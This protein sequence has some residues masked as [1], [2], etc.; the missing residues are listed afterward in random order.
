MKQTLKLILLFLGFYPQFLRSLI[1]DPK[2]SSCDFSANCSQCQI[3]YNID[4]VSQNCVS[5]CNNRMYFFEPSKQCVTSCPQGFIENQQTKACSSINQCDQLNYQSGTKGFQF[6]ASSQVYKNLLIVSGTQNQTADR[7]SYFNVYTLKNDQYGF[8]MFGTLDGHNSSVISQIMLDEQYS[9]VL[10]TVSKNMI[11]AWDMQYGALKSRL[12]F[13]SKLFVDEN[14]FYLDSNILVLNY[15]NKNQFAVFSHKDWVKSLFSPTQI[16]STSSFFTKFQK[17]H[18]IPI[19]GYELLSTNYLISFDSN[20]VIQWNINNNQEQKIYSNFNFTL[21]QIFSFPQ[22]QNQ[23]NTSLIVVTYQQNNMISFILSDNNP[24]ILSFNT[25]HQSPIASILFDQNIQVQNLMQQNIF[26]F[27]SYSLT[28][29][30]IFQFNM[31]TYQYLLIQNFQSQNFLIKQMNNQ[32][33]IL[34]SSGLNLISTQ[35]QQQQPQQQP[36]LETLNISLLNIFQ[37]KFSPVDK[38]IDI[39]Q[40]NI[41]NNQAFLVIGRELKIFSPQIQQGK[42]VYILKNLYSKNIDYY[43]RHNG[44]INGVAFD[45]S[46]NLF[47]TYSSDGSFAVWDTILNNMLNQKPLYFQLPP[48][49]QNQ[50]FCQI[51][52]KKAQVIMNGV[53]LTL[54]SNNIFITWNFSRYSVSLRQTYQLPS[55]KLKILNY[56]FFN[57]YL[58]MSNNKEL[59]IYNFSQNETQLINTQYQVFTENITQIQLAQLNT[60]FYLL[61]TL[62]VLSPNIQSF[63]RVKYLS[64]LTLFKNT[65]IQ[66]QCLELQYFQQTQKIIVNYYSLNLTVISFPSLNSTN[67]QSADNQIAVQVYS[68]SQNQFLIITSSTLMY[69]YLPNGTN[70]QLNYPI[71]T[72]LPRTNFGI[73]N[74]EQFIVTSIGYS[75]FQNTGFSQIG[76]Y[77]INLI[78]SNYRTCSV[79]PFK[80]EVSSLSIINDSIVFVGF[81]NGNIQIAEYSCANQICGSN[82]SSIYNSITNQYLKKSYFFTPSKLIIA[83]LYNKS[84]ITL[85][86]GHSQSTTIQIIQDDLSG[87]MITY[88]QE[89]TQN[90][91]KFDQRNLIATQ[92]QNGHNASVDYAFLDVNRSVLIT[93]SADLNDLQVIV[94]SY[95][96]SI[97]LNVFLDIQQFNQVTPI[98]SIATALIDMVS[99]Q[100][101]ILTTQ[102]TLFSFNYI[103]YK[104]NVQYLVQNVITIYLDP[105]FFKFYLLCNSNRIQIRNYFT[106]NLENEIIAN[107]P[108]LLQTIAPQVNWIVVVSQTYLT[109]INRNKQS[110]QSSIFC[111]NYCGNYVVS[112][113]LNILFS[114]ASN[115]SNGLDVYNIING[116]YLYS[117]NGYEDLNI[118]TIRLVLIDDVNYLLF[119]GKLSFFTTAV[120]N[121]LTQQYIGYAFESIFLFYGS[122]NNQFN[123]LNVASTGKFYIRSLQEQVVS[124]FK[125]QDYY[126]VKQIDYYTSSQGDIYYLDGNQYVRKYSQLDSQIKIVGQLSNYRQ[127]QYFNGF[128]YVLTLKQLIKYTDSFEQIPQNSAL[129]IFGNQI[130]GVK[131]NQIFISTFNQTIVQVDYQQFII[132]NQINLPS[133]LIQYQFIESFNDLLIISMDGSFMRYNYIS[134][135][136][137]IQISAGYYYFF[138]NLDFNLIFLASSVRQQIEVYSYSNQIANFSNFLLNNITYPNTTIVR[139]IFMDQQFS[140][141]YISSQNDRIIDIYSYQ[142][143]KQALSISFTKVNYIPYINAAKYLKLRFVDKYIQVQIPWSISYYDRQS[144]N[145]YWQVQDPMFIQSINQYMIDPSF[146]ELVFI[147]QNT[148]LTIV[149]QNIATQTFNL[150]V[151]YSLDYPIIYKLQINK[152]FD[153]YVFQILLLVSGDILNYQ[154]SIPIVNGIPQQSYFNNCNLQISNPSAQFQVSNQLLNLQSYFSSFNYQSQGIQILV[155]FKLKFFYQLT[156]FIQYYQINGSNFIYYSD[157]MKSLNAITQYQG[158]QFSDSLDVDD[159]LFINN[160]NFEFDLS[161]YNLVL[162]SRPVIAQFSSFTNVLQFTNISFSQPDQ[163]QNVNTTIIIENMSSVVFKNITLRQI[164]LQGN[165]SLFSFYNCSNVTLDNIQIENIDLF[166]LVSIFKFQA[167]SNLSIRNLQLKQL[168]YQDSINRIL[169]ETN[170]QK[171]YLF[172][173]YQIQNFLMEKAQI[174][175]IKGDGNQII[176]DIQQSKQNRFNNI[177]LRSILNVQTISYINFFQES[178]QTRFLDNDIFIL[179]NF[180]ISNYQNLISSVIYF[181]GTQLQILNSQFSYI[182]CQNCVGSSLNIYQTESIIISNSQFDNNFGLNGGSLGLIE[183]VGNQSQIINSQFINNKA[184]NSGGA[185]YLSKSY[186]KLSNDLF[187]ENSALIGGAIRYINGKPKYFTKD[188]FKSSGVQFISNS[189]EIHSQNWGSYLQYVTPQQVNIKKNRLIQQQLQE[190][191]NLSLKQRRLSKSQYQLKDIQ[192]GGFVDLQFQIFDEEN[193]I[194]NYNITKC[195]YQIY[196]QQICDELSQ[197]ELSIFSEDVNIV[198]IVGSYMAQYNSFQQSLSAFQI[199]GIQ[200]VGNPSSTQFIILSAFGLHQYEEIG[201]QDLIYERKILLFLTQI[202]INNFLNQKVSPNIYQERYEINFR[203]CIIGE[204]YQLSSDIYYC[205]ECLQGTYSLET[206]NKSKNIMQCKLCPEEASFCFKNQMELKSGY[207]KSN[208][209]TDL[210]YKCDFDENCKGDQTTNYCNEGHLG[211]LCQFCDEYGVLWGQQYQ[212]N[213]KNGCVNCTTM[214]ILYAI[215]NAFIISTILALFFIYNIFQSIKASQRVVLAHYLRIFKFLCISRSSQKN[216]VNLAVKA[217]TSFLQLY[218]LISNFN[219]NLPSIVSI[220]PDLFGQPSSSAVFNTACQIAYLVTD[221][222][223]HLYWKSLFSILS[224]LMFAKLMGLYYFI[225]VHKKYNIQL[226]K[227]QFIF[228]I[229]FLFQYTQP[230]IVQYLIQLITCRQFDGKSYIRADYTYE[231]YTEQHK[232]YILLLIGPGLLL[233]RKQLNDALVRL[234]YGYIYQDY[235]EKCFYWEIAKSEQDIQKAIKNWMM[236]YQR[237]QFNKTPTLPISPKSPSIYMQNQ[238]EFPERQQLNNSNQNMMQRSGYRIRNTLSSLIAKRQFNINQIQNQLQVDTIIETQNYRQTD[239]NSLSDSP[240]QYIR[241]S[242]LSSP[243][244][245]KRNQGSQQSNRTIQIDTQMENDLNS[246]S[247]APNTLQQNTICLSSFQQCWNLVCLSLNLYKKCR[248]YQGGFYPKFLESLLCDSKCASCDFLANCSQCQIGYNLDPNSQNCISQCREGMF[249]YEPTQQCLVNCPQGFFENQQTKACASINQCDQIT[250]QSD[251]KGFNY[252]INSQVYQDLLIVRGKQ[253]QTVVEN[254]L[255]IYKLKN[256]QYGFYTYGVLEGHDSSIIC[257]TLL[258]DQYSQVLISASKKMIKAWDMEYGILKSSLNLTDILFVDEFSFYLDKTIL[259]LNYFDRNQ[260]A[261]FRHKDWVKSLYYPDQIA[262]TSSLFTMFKRIHTRPIIGYQTL[263]SNY[264]ISF[265]NSIVIRWNILDNNEYYIYSNFNYTLNQ[266]Y[267]FPYQNNQSSTITAITYVENTFISFI[268]YNN[269]SQQIENKTFILNSKGLSLIQQPSEDQN[270]QL[271]NIFQVSFSSSDK[272]M[273]IQK[274][275]VDNSLAFIIIGREL[276]IF[277][278]QIQQESI[279]FT[280]QSLIS[281][282]QGSYQRHNGQVNGVVYDQSQNLFITYSS[283]GS[284]AVWDTIQNSI[285]NQKPLYFQFPPWCQFQDFCQTPLS[286]AQLIMNRVILSLYKIVTQVYSPIQNSFLIITSLSYMYQYLPNGTSYSLNYPVNYP[287]PRTNFGQVYRQQFVVTSTGFSYFQNTGFS[288]IGNYVINLIYEDYRTCSVFPFQD[289]ISSLSVINDSFIFVGFKNGN[290]KIA[291]YS[292]TNQVLGTNACNTQNIITNPY[293]KKTYYFALSTVIVAD[294]YSKTSTSIPYGHPSTYSVKVIQDDLNGNMITYSQENSQNLYKFDQKSQIATQFQNGHNSSVDYA[295]LDLKNNLVI[296]HSADTKDLQV[297]VWS[298]IYVSKLYV[299]LDIKQFNLIT[300]IIS[301]AAALLDIDRQNKQSYQSNIYCGD[302]CGNYVVSDKLNLLFSYASNNSNGLDV[303]NI[304]NGQY[305]YSIIGYEDLN[306]GTI[307]LV[308]IDDVN[309][310]LFIGKLSFFT[311]AVFNYLTQ[312]YV[313]YAFDRNFLFYG[314]INNQ[315][316]ALNGASSTRYYMRTLQEYVVSTFKFQDQYKLKK[317]DYYTSSIGELYFIDANGYV[318]RYNQQDEQIKIV[319]QITSYRQIQYFNGFLLVLTLQ[320]LFKYTEGFQQVNQGSFINMFGDQILGVQNNQIFISTFNQTIVQVD[321]QQFIIVNQINLQSSIIQYQFIESYNDL[322]LTTQDGRLI[323]Y[324]YINNSTLT[325]LSGGYYLFYCNLDLNLIFIVSSLNQQIE[326]YSYSNQLFN[327]TNYLLRNITYPNTTIIRQMFIDQQFNNLY[328]AYKNDRIIDIYSFQIN[329]LSPNINF[330]KVNFIP[331]INVVQSLKL[332]LVDQYI[333]VRIPSSITFYDRQSFN[334]YWQ[335][336]DPLFIQSINQYMIDPSF[337]ELVFITQNTLLVIVYQKISSKTFNLLVKQTLDYPIIYN[338]K[339]NKSFD[340]YFIQFLLLVSGDIIKY[341]VSIPIVNNIPQQ[342]YFNNCFLQIDNP[343]TQFQI[344]NQLIDLQ[345]YFSTFN[346]QSEAIQL[347]INGSNSLYYYDGMNS[348]NAQ[349]KYQG[350]Q[351]NSNL[352]IEDNL[353]YQ[354]QN[355]Q[356]NIINYNL[357]LL[358]KPVIAQFN[359]QTNSLQ[360]TNITFIQIDQTQQVNSTIIIQNMTN[361]IFQNV[362][363]SQIKLQG[364]ISLFN[365]FNCSNIIFENIQIENIQ[366]FD[367]VSIFR[368]QAVSNITLNNLSINLYTKTLDDDS[369]ELSK[370]T[371][372]NYENQNQSLISFQGTY[373]LIQNSQFSF[374]NCQDC[375]GSSINIYKSNTVIISNSIF[376]NNTGLNGGS[377]GIIE[378]QGNQSSIVNSQ[379]IKNYAFNSGG[380]IYLDSSYIK[381]TQDIFKEN[382]ALIGGAIRYLNG[383][384]INFNSKEFQSNGVQFISNSASI[385]S[386]N[387]GSYLQYVVLKQII[388]SKDRIIEQQITNNHDKT[389]E[390]SDKKNQKD[391]YVIDN[392]QSG[393]FINLQLQIYDEEDN[394]LNYNI[395]NCINQIYPQEICDELSQIEIILF[396]QDTNIVRVVGSYVAQYN[397]FLQPISA[398]QILGIQIMGDPKSQQFIFLQAQGLKQY[399]KTNQFDL[400]Q[401]TSTINYQ[402]QYKLVFRDC[403]IGEIYKLSD[404]I[405]QCQEC[406]KGTYSLQTPNKKYFTDEQIQCKSCPEEAS[407]CFKNQMELKAGYWKS[408]NSTDLIYQCEIEQ[409]CNGDQTKQYCIEGH[410]GPL[411]QFCDE[412]GYLWGQ[413][414]QYDSKHGCINCTTLNIISALS[415]FIII[416]IVIIFFF[417]FNIFQTIKASQKVI[418]A[419]YLRFLKLLCIS[420]SSQNNEVNLVVKALTSF[421]Q[422]YKLISNFDLKLPQILSIA[423]SLFGEPSSQAILNSACQIASLASEKMPHLYWKLLFS[424]LSP[425]IFAFMMLLIYLILIHKKYRIQATKSQLIFSIVFLFQYTQ[426]NIVQNLIQQITCKDFDGKK[427]IKADYTYECYT[428]QHINFIIFMISPALLLYSIAYPTFIFYILYKQRKQLTRA[429][430]RLRYG[431]IYQDYKEKCFY[432]EI[433]KYILKLSIILVLNFYNPTYEKTKFLAVFLVIIVYYLALVF[434]KPYQINK[435]QQIDQNSSVVLI[436]VSLLNYFLNS[437][438]S[439]FEIYLY[440]YLLLLCQYLNSGYLILLIIRFQFMANFDFILNKIISKLPCKC[441][442]LKKI[443]VSS[444]KD[445]QKAIKNWMIVYKIFKSNKLHKPS[446]TYDKN[447]SAQQEQQKQTSTDQIMLEKTRDFKS[448]SIFRFVQNKKLNLS[449]VYNTIE[450]DQIIESQEENQFD[451][452]TQTDYSPMN[453]QDRFIKSI[454]SRFDRGNSQENENQNQQ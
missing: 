40:I 109:I 112:D 429:K 351:N 302:Y 51:S 321:I 359:S 111:G 221:N 203:D 313:S 225:L 319:G 445:I 377:L 404:Q 360:F 31:N 186:V 87:N 33:L 344:Q 283:D 34:N 290:I 64:N 140:N 86:Y 7:E 21:S 345:N 101:M 323:R 171:Q 430:V 303:F 337:P 341:Q 145:F 386:Q 124:A 79:F 244:N 107:S 232:K 356:L 23:L 378:C 363:L 333:Q 126:K 138:C 92:F 62:Q 165:I 224:P 53:I 322:L 35:Q 264:L 316:N 347:E 78:Y 226:S 73:L 421:L 223:P 374:V 218:K 8:Q 182:N 320:K 369:F 355:H 196:P 434:F 114:Y 381:L 190:T 81:K 201:N 113:K 68:P 340:L 88:S 158:N 358:A 436:V 166:D 175:S 399:N 289:E 354:N 401:K 454:F 10:I 295:F 422:L 249:Y 414:Y 54:Y 326:V 446:Y 167:I 272:I 271:V 260:F 202:F 255:N 55:Q 220:A 206:P 324:N 123:V 69:Q 310:L 440:Q 96:Y 209:L 139:Q 268:L 257:L 256:D 18:T 61:E 350:N 352:N 449:G 372:Q 5:Q 390:Q 258:D 49:C 65:S 308:L 418:V 174:E 99:Q 60:T 11:I 240:L 183:C 247:S 395:S 362:K 204:I 415:Q 398:F 423:P 301:I 266:L 187:K 130:L 231:C 348:L 281:K 330:T 176:F 27:I 44:Q 77:V 216:E 1:C 100:V 188:D 173:F 141:V 328:I 416:L 300:P 382:F 373:L 425:F 71:N 433:P 383:R 116:S 234:R 177:Y 50:D 72:P 329:K 235:K 365:L 159:N 59:Q 397:A 273:D 146:P 106:M 261:I 441:N 293:L 312:Q 357:V 410:Y 215:F 24:Q 157:Q 179:T 131:N 120:F 367:L 317:I 307:R 453:T 9:Q 76:N 263:S 207:W 335:I 385:H 67:I 200:I 227:S 168:S 343:S 437:N 233:S 164:N 170:Q 309:Y 405:Y 195:T 251:Y 391:Q 134:N 74:K 409:N 52:L 117:I 102:G 151:K 229:V 193:N 132:V 288:Q 98:I 41:D 181:K 379:F 85:P 406:I 152:N 285:L 292:C 19:L 387:F 291:E 419:Y 294:L 277:Q 427:Y 70:Y 127:I 104:V 364:N 75:Y 155:K 403:E 128:V 154:I 13:T 66:Q 376:N 153:Q 142:F 280:Q 143:N 115:N 217:F 392:L 254:Y 286:N 57:Q 136:T 241:N 278:Q 189:A 133:S 432:W 371:I 83:D 253:N 172:Q 194:L 331:Y 45:Q 184:S 3:G 325:Q 296:S 91:Y 334:I 80:D 388:N 82:S 12:I 265:D 238:I 97:K 32:T 276:K 407:Y 228:S 185:I 384:P 25:D 306:V 148:L 37:A 400:I 110:Y 412:K 30:K 198:R 318:R 135:T 396:S 210:I 161:N 118:G 366:I 29:I 242:S 452:I 230:N 243:L 411:C 237:L 125:Y 94:W 375:L 239:C 297:I 442:F 346:Y 2:C 380:A 28:E 129:N 197:I 282:N 89:K 22:Y 222:M 370:F 90:L 438:T 394:L 43:Q 339:I 248:F 147:T 58:F 361:V 26:Q 84:S 162:L 121:Y 262:S 338:L 305:I 169:I 279:I 349:V 212:Y 417:L 4:P 150:L 63:L 208:N 275:N 402:D 163:T 428:E 353:F 342:S 314:A 270:L 42:Q 119:I 137:L 424:I 274:V 103:T 368:F 14:S 444:G 408:N 284:F 95:T 160:Q 15:I 246:F 443:K 327:F 448:E 269:S 250:F 311:T 426:P 46:Q 439:R 259:I 149:Y 211:P 236:L 16:T 213:N 17:I 413:Q 36:T 287:L 191:D 304:I 108:I 56:G 47:I 431:Y 178:I 298:Y 180:N 315:F 205:H 245:Q 214:T 389:F 20:K 38:I 299:F 39:H 192:S 48:Q 435:Y 6:H 450:E 252:N 93:H 420:R 156:K 267:A 393:G 336:Q 144:F 105:I 199:F 447:N 122:I 219:I 332:S 451:Q